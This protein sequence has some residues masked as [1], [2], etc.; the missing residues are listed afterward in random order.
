[1]DDLHG[2]THDPYNKTGGGTPATA[3][4]AFFS[5]PSKK[6]AHTLFSKEL[7]L[8]ANPFDHMQ[9]IIYFALDTF[10]TYAF[11]VCIAL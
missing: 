9:S 3:M 5:K 11:I 7:H 4:C 6:Y 2:R 1:M 10:T 8:C